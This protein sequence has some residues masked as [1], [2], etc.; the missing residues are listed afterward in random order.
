LIANAV[1]LQLGGGAC[2]TYLYTKPYAKR[3]DALYMP[4]GYQPPRF[5]QFDR[6]GNPKQHVAHFVETYNNA[7]INDDLMVKQ[8]DQTLKG[9]A[10]NYC[11][12]L[13]PESIDT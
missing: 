6:K 10:F 3:V 2:K 5:Q 12:D 8:L 11:T 13:E 9:I 1:K 4:R 7:G